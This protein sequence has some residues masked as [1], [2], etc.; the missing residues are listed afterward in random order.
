MMKVTNLRNMTHT[1]TRARAPHALDLGIHDV[2]YTGHVIAA[3]CWRLTT[4]PLLSG[5][6]LLGRNSKGFLSKRM[7]M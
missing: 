3:E 1:H 7:R 2:T 5:V 4:A 6:V